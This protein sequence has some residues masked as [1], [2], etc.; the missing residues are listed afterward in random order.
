MAKRNA[1]N[2]HGAGTIRQRSDGRWEARYTVGRDL[3]TGKQIQRS[4]YGKTQKEVLKKLREVSVEVEDGVYIEPKKLTVSQWLDI[5]LEEYTGNL[6]PLTVSAYHTQCNNHIKP[7][8]GAANLLS[9]TP[10]A[11]QKMYNSLYRKDKLSA[12]TVKNI[13][14]VLHRALQQAVKIGYLRYNPADN[15][16]LPRVYRKE[17]K[18]LDEKQIKAFIDALD[19]ERYKT[20]YLVTLFTGMR[21]GE[22][23][24]L[25]W[26]CVDFENNLITV[27]KQ[28]Q[29]E[30]KANSKYYFAPLK[31][32]KSRT[33]APAPYVM[34]L[35]KEQRLTQLE[36]K[37]KCGAAWGLGDKL[38]D[39][40]VF[41]DEIGKHLAAHTV[42][43]HYKAIAEKI[44]VPDSRFHDLRHTYA[45]TALQNGD[46]VKTVQE[47]LGHHTAA[48]TLD[49]YGHVTDKMKRESAERMERFIKSI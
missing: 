30:K 10:A 2:A 3:G 21:Q 11:V 31:N 40:L 42:Y 4:I 7:Y 25:Q 20:L 9:L 39:N 43:K 28:L 26:S 33:I 23:L 1:R 32:D 6:K 13:H 16:T 44:G 5:W 12:K 35:L 29:R 49:V 47:T 27:N 36:Q 14:G 22:V 41:T 45:V 17:I 48:F 24:G 46:D 34:Q 19:N 15:C 38:N 8:I 37:A 18:P